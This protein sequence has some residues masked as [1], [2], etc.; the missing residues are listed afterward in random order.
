MD[1]QKIRRENRAGESRGSLPLLRGILKKEEIRMKEKNEMQE[2]VESLLRKTKKEREKS[3]TGSGE[4]LRLRGK[5][6]GL[7]ELLFQMARQ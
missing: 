3:K 4:W 2:M 6:E 1:G 5:E 7:N